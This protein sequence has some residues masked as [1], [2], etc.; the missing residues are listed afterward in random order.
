MR[1]TGV[2]NWKEGLVLPDEWQHVIRRAQA[3]HETIVN[4]GCLTLV[5]LAGRDAFLF[6]LEDRQ[7]GLRAVSR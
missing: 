3:R 7:A 5:A 6:D 1:R 4:L 2:W